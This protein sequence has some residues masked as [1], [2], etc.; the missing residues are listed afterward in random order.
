MGRRDKQKKFKFEDDEDELQGVKEGASKSANSASS[1][2]DEANEDLSLKIVEKAL[3]LRSGKLVAVAD[4]NKDG[5]REQC[6]TGDVAGVGDAG[7]GTSGASADDVTAASEV[8]ELG[9]KKTV[10]KRKRKVKKLGTGEHDV[11]IF[12][13]PL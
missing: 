1:D 2:D 4:D 3:L 9:S 5:S 8:R 12:L 10:K 11:S 6:G 7:A 13:L